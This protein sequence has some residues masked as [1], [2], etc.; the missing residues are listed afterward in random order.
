MELSPLINSLQQS[1]KSTA[2]P[3]GKDV[4]EAAALL[5]Q[6]LEPAAR[7]CL[8][9]AMSGAADEITL[10][11]ENT[12]VEARL[13]GQDIDFVVNELTQTE[14]T[15]APTESTESQSND[16]VARITLRIPESLKD[17]VE[18]A[19]KSE[20]LSVNGWLVSAIAAAV[21]SAPQSGQGARHG[22]RNRSYKGFARS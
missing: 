10:A 1:L 15:T 17:S 8:L 7:L 16:D 19:A 14:T 12:S 9:E 18:Q 21:E 11:L 13:R 2:A 3:A 4:A 22:K 5:A 6:S 20:S